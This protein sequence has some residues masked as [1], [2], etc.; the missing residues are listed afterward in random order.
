MYDELFDYYVKVGH[1][2]QYYRL[3]SISAR[4]FRNVYTG[5]TL[6]FSSAGFVA[7]TIWDQFP[8]LWA[9]LMLF[10]Q[11]VQALC[12]LFQASKQREALKF[13]LQDT[14]KIFNEVAKYWNSI[15]LQKRFPDLKQESEQDIHSRI[16]EWRERQTQLEERVTGD[17]DL[18]VKKRLAAKA[19]IENEHYFWYHCNTKTKEEYHDE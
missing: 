19:K 5:I 18:P 14:T 12:P 1:D 4:R 9:L 16:F 10:A 11:A 7:L 3:Y 17:V 6:L 15:Q 13:I 2:L 8:I